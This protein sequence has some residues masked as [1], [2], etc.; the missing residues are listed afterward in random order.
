MTQLCHDLYEKT[1]TDDTAGIILILIPLK[2][3]RPWLS[4]VWLV[5]VAYAPNSLFRS[6]A[7]SVF[8]W[9]INKILN[10]I[11]YVHIL[12][13]FL[14]RISC[15]ECLLSQDSCSGNDGEMSRTTRI[16]N[17]YIQEMLAKTWIIQFY[18]HLL[19]ELLKTLE[20][21]RQV[22]HVRYRCPSLN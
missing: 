18:D 1:H 3:D 8:T 22:L 16:G 20:N 2:P 19:N 9:V 15:R 17:F 10:T 11:L 13:N 6:N 7:F 5:Y 4:C 14:S 12:S 21:Y